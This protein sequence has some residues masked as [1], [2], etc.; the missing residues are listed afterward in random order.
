MASFLKIQTNLKKAQ[1][2]S[3]EAGKILTRRLKKAC[4]SRWLSFD[5]SVSSALKEY[6]SI[7]L[8]LSEFESSDATASGLLGK[9]KQAKFFGTLHILSE[10]L[11][12]LSNL[13]K[14]LQDNNVNFS[15]IAPTVEL[16]KSKL[17]AIKENSSAMSDLEKDLDSLLVGSD[18][19][20]MTPRVADELTN[21]Q[22]KYIDALVKNIDARFSSDSE[23][24]SSFSVFNPVSIPPSDDPGFLEYGNLQIHI[25]ANHFC[26]DKLE[27]VKAEWT[28]LKYYV[29]KNITMPSH[30]KKSYQL[31]PAVL[32]EAQV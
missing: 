7:I 27:Q 28:L 19:I 3:K 1:E 13:S 21:M 6:E 22:R 16:T 18:L 5:N 31:V 4:G 29:N 32:D 15:H 20:K 30:V 17:E 26:P 14:S 11:P 2:P 8:C 24:V 23:V 25:L 10:I 12:V 9:L